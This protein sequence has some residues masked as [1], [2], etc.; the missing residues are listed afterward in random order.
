MCNKSAYYSKRGKHH[1]RHGHGHGGRHGHPGR[2]FK[3]MARKFAQAM[4]QP[5]VN[6]EEQDDRYDLFVYAAGYAK[7]DFQINVKDNNLI[8]EVKK[9]EKEEESHPNWRRQEFRAHNFERWFELNDKID[10]DAISA[11]YK[12]GILKVTLPKLEGEETFR[13][14]VKVQ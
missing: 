10:K 5:P 1:H 3:H 14:E 12:D 2:K 7:S 6:V 4:G 13:Q 8:I 9:E 11:E